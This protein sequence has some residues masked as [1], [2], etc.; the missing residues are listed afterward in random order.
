MMAMMLL[1]TSSPAIADDF[2][3]DDDFEVSGEIDG[4]PVVFEYEV[5]CVEDDNDVDGLFGEDFFDGLHNDFDG[6][7]DEDDVEC[8]MFLTDIDAG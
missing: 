3:F 7:I 4:I 8:E 1:A 5:E 6:S 2:G